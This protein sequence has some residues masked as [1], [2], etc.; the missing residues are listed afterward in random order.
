MA[1]KETKCAVFF[2]IWASFSSLIEF[3]QKL[4][5]YGL[6]KIIFSLL[7][8]LKMFQ[9]SLLDLRSIEELGQF[10][11][12]LP[13]TIESE[14]LFAHIESIHFTTK[15]F[16]QILSQQQQETISASNSDN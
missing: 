4:N 10:L 9:L 12:K 16:T 13:S 14:S 15:R 2:L 3:H 8:I 5:C 7:G 1:C 6:S 11:G